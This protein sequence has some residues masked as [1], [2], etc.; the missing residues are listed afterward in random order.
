MMIDGFLRTENQLHYFLHNEYVH[1]R[2]FI[3][4]YLDVSRDVAIAR[5][6]A[7]AKKE[8]RAD[9]NVKS[10]ETRL[11]IYEKETRPVIDYFKKKWRLIVVD[12]NEWIDVSFVELIEKMK[13]NWLA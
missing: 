13:E 5:L 11:D 6:M 4:I 1:K 7:R 10:I 2:D 3:W 8:W 9:D 12:A